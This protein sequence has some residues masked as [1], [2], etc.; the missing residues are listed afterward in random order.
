M[1]D[2]T[3]WLNEIGLPQYV[4]LFRANNIDGDVLSSLTI[5]D[6]KELARPAV[7]AGRPRQVARDAG[8]SR[9]PR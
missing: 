9:E 6:L 4:E 2:V 5:E 3:R 1:V 8:V 7:G